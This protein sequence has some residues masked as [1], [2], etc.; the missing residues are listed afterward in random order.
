MYVYVCGLLCYAIYY[1]ILS[2]VLVNKNLMFCPQRATSDRPLVIILDSLDQLSKSHNAH[3]LTWLPKQLPPHVYLVVSTLQYEYDLLETLRANVG[4]ERN[5]VEVVD[6]GAQLGVELVQEW[7]RMEKRAITE[8]QLT[9]V[10][11]ANNKCSLPIY[12]RLI[13]EEVN[14]KNFMV[15][16]DV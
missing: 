5:F 11:H 13:F 8:E 15:L 10:Q 14:I 16:W 7:L 9:I 2:P 1:T 3:D 4:H 12:T 6:L